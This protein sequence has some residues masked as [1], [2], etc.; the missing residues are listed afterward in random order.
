MCN[1]TKIM[2]INAIMFTLC[3]A[4]LVEYATPNTEMYK[5]P[6]PEDNHK[7]IR[8]SAQVHHNNLR[9][10]GATP[11]AKNIEVK[12][13]NTTSNCGINGQCRNTPDGFMCACD[14]GYYSMEENSPCA[15]KGE[16]QTKMA[17]IWYF[18]GWT[19]ASAFVL[20]WVALGV[21]TLLTCCCGCYGINI[22]KVDKYSDNTRACA[23]IIG[24]C[25]YIT[26]FS[27]WI[28]VAVSISSGSKCVN[29]EGVPCDKW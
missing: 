8:D 10:L 11:S 6:M 1:L 22:S 18:F 27:L 26:C 9:R 17:V 28:Y 29:E 14:S 12:C 23:F 20:G 24:F 16:S 3:Y 7:N 19:G 4:E 13:F 15:V 2:M 25:S 21:S 5:S